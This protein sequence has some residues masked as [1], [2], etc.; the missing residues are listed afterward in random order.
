MFESFNWSI[1]A[2]TWQEKYVLR[3][4]I[5]SYIRENADIRGA[6]VPWDKLWLLITMYY[7]VVFSG[8][9]CWRDNISKELPGSSCELL[10]LGW[11]LAGVSFSWVDLW[12]RWALN[13]WDL[14][15]RGIYMDINLAE[16]TSSFVGLWMPR[17]L[18]WPLFRRALSGGGLWLGRTLTWLPREWL[19]IRQIGGR[20]HSSSDVMWKGPG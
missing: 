20:R 1:Q 4:G 7:H 9:V 3:S 16:V 13:E 19:L 6:W 10:W 5:A 18:G 12:L 15:E 8:D 2:V 14:T 11:S 17:N